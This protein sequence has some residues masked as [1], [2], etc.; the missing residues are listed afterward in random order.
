MRTIRRRA[1]A[2]IEGATSMH[3]EMK[4]ARGIFLRKTLMAMAVAAAGL[5]LGPA[6]QAGVAIDN[7]VVLDP[8]DPVPPIQFQHWYGGERH[9]HHRYGCDGCRERVADNCEDGCGRGYRHDGCDRDCDGSYRRDRCDRGCDRV[10]Y[11]CQGD[12]RQR[13]GAAPEPCVQNCYDAERWEHRWRNGDRIGQEWYD[14]G[15]RE[16][17]RASDRG[18]RQW[19]GKD[20][21]NDWRDTDDDDSSAPPPPADNHDDHGNRD[22][23]GDHY[24][25]DDH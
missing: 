20:D 24:D 4:T 5:A 3:D 23:H 2:G 21:D 8:F 25:H 18:D 13:D 22:H 16:R 12:C 15:S 7:A 9:F 1:P 14:S 19:Y 11:R 6:A 10:E 17:Q